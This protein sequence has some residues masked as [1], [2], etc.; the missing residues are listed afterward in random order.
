MTSFETH[1]F[2][3]VCLSGSMK[4]IH[5]DEVSPNTSNNWQ[6][7]SNVVSSHT[8]S[9][10]IR[11]VNVYNMKNNQKCNVTTTANWS[12][13][14]C[15][16]VHVSPLKTIV[17]YMQSNHSLFSTHVIAKTKTEL[18]NKKEL[19]NASSLILNMEGMV[20]VETNKTCI[21]KENTNKDCL[22]VTNTT[23]ISKNETNRLGTKT[24]VGIS[25]IVTHR[26]RSGTRI[27][28][29]RKGVTFN[30][31]RLI[32]T[33]NNTSTETYSLKRTA[34]IPRSII[35]TPDI[36]PKRPLTTFLYK[37]SSTASDFSFTANLESTLLYD[38][39]TRTKRED[40]TVGTRKQTFS[41]LPS[42][43]TSSVPGLKSTREPKTSVTSPRS[44]THFTWANMER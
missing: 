14:S 34:R 27:C 21:V 43:A 36:K 9:A 39:S 30:E 41:S 15:H 23:E 17:S 5:A 16:S 40:H 24:A 18:M 4:E 22:K 12:F 8:S 11:H 37:T 31:T 29:E 2:R 33:I 44:N 7:V 42:H 26:Y 38:S 3:S 35:C 10:E 28:T 6:S 20:Y 1:V 19:C 32:T 13:R 25:E